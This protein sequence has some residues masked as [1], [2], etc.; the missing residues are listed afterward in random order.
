MRGMIAS[1]GKNSSNTQMRSAQ[2][3]STSKRI[4]RLRTHINVSTSMGFVE[5]VLLRLHPIILA[6]RAVH[7]REN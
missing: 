4:E 2:R 1:L 3:A 5:L 6:L 7:D